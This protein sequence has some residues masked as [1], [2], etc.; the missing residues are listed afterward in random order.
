MWL[1]KSSLSLQRIPQMLHWNGSSTAWMP[2]C[3]QYITL[4]PKIMSQFSQTPFP[5]PARFSIR[6]HFG[7]HLNAFLLNI[8]DSLYCLMNLGFCYYESLICECLCQIPWLNY[9]RWMLFVLFHTIT[10]HRFGAGLLL[11]WSAQRSWQHTL[12]DAG[13]PNLFW[14]VNIWVRIPATMCS[15]LVLAVFSL[16]VP[17]SVLIFDEGSLAD[18]AFTESSHLISCTGNNMLLECLIM[19]QVILTQRTDLFCL[20]HRFP[21]SRLGVYHLKGHTPEK[22]KDRIFIPLWFS[23]LPTVHAAKCYD[24]SRLIT[25]NF[26]SHVT[27]LRGF[28]VD[29]TRK[30]REFCVERGDRARR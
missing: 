4:S 5:L 2:L 26:E 28:C 21:R 19:W 8:F 1:K 25:W 13:I 7:F 12:S 3:M 14:Y 18:L 20:C 6:T 17:P 23:N 9:C 15:L 30:Y 11:N 16:H 24:Q 22:R 10:L 29:I 27:F